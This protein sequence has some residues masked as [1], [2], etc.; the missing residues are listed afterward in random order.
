L[1]EDLNKM[2][3]ERGRGDGLL[4]AFAVGA[5]FI[6]IAI[7]FVGTPNILNDIGKFFGDFT[8]KQVPSTTIFL[9]APAHPADHAELYGALAQFS[10]GV[11]ILQILILALRLVL[12]SSVRRTAETVGNLVFWFGAIYLI[13]TFLN[14][15][16]TSDMWFM[17]WAALLVACGVSMIA[18]ALVLFAKKSLAK[19]SAPNEQ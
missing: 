16:T 2:R 13:N 17:F 8:T 10:I 3:R 19:K 5:V 15:A 14:N 6:L 9:P 4:S 7:I 18:R 12:G 11:G 1:S